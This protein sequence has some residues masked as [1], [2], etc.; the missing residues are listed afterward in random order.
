M[1][2]KTLTALTLALLV[3]IGSYA[4]P[5]A[6]GGNRGGERS[7]PNAQ[8]QTLNAQPVTGTFQKMIVENGSVTMDLDANG[9]AGDG[10]LVARPIALHFVIAANSFFPILVFNDLL[11]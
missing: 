2:K 8:R 11:R 4:V 9:L 6:T 5:S 3:L 1:F 7:T 10:S